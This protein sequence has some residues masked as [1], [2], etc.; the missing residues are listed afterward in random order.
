MAAANEASAA[1]AA[2]ATAQRDA[3]VLAEAETKAN[4]EA[5]A[6]ARLLWE[7]TRRQIAEAG[8]QASATT[9]EMQKTATRESEVALQ[10]FDPKP[11]PNRNPN[12][13]PNRNRNRNRNLTVTLTLTRWPSSDSTRTLPRRRA[14]PWVL[15]V[16]TTPR[17]W[18]SGRRRRRRSASSAS[19]W[20]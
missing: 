12:P 10:R 4:M 6:A 14:S 9:R 3:D 11:N 17:R 5:D 16:R 8:A 1:A 13:N 2:A 19:R 7:D 20:A 18:R 15:R